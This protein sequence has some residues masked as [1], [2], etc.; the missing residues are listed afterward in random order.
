MVA[1]MKKN[2][3]GSRHLADVLRPR[4]VSPT[5][6]SAEEWSSLLQTSANTLT[7]SYLR[8]LQSVRQILEPDM[9]L[10]KG[11]R[12]KYYAPPSVIKAGME[13]VG[14]KQEDV[15]LLCTELEDET[16][17]YVGGTYDLA[18]ANNIKGVHL[19]MSKQGGFWL[20]GVRW[21]HNQ[22]YADH[23][24][25]WDSDDE[26]FAAEHITLEYVGFGKPLGNFCVGL[27]KLTD[28]GI[29][30]LGVFW[31]SRPIGQIVLDAL[32]T[33]QRETVNYLESRG[34]EASTAATTLEGFS[35]RLEGGK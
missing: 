2:L 1:T 16:A 18:K 33:A 35:S 12:I 31:N 7:L 25:P 32:C 23:P 28:E 34:R 29:E 13:E 4:R 22:V 10:Q 8:G 27:V 30:Q 17:T 5:S 20:L 15:F 24:N 21:S 9:K 3:Q 11:L 26:W 14:M 19:I 6:L